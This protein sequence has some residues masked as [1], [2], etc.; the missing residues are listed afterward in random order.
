[1]F[2]RVV[3]R[4]LASPHYGERWGRHWLDV[5]RY[6]D[7]R[8]LIQLPVES[9]F[10]EAWRYRDWVVESF[11]R[12]MPYTEF[13]KYQIAGDLL[14]PRDPARIDK[15]ALVATGMLA[16]ADFVPGDTDKEMMIADYVNDQIDVVGR[17]FMGLTLA[18][19]RCHNHK[20]DPISTRDY[21]SL[22][23]IFF[24]TRLVPA[25]VE[26]NTPLIRVPLLAPAEI[27]MAEAQ[28]A[29]N[30]KRQRELERHLSGAAEGG[31][32]A[33]LKGLAVD[34]TERGPWARCG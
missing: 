20:F 16:I 24:S 13:L 10:R 7:A 14:Q 21:Y 6:A 26:G 8:D 30:N 29:A 32:R 15:D 33:Y 19:A 3:D 27:A 22:A 9:D 11:N 25:P 12:D 34:Q 2:A 28:Q 4:L 23:G 5:V 1:A 18:C 31:G 17:A